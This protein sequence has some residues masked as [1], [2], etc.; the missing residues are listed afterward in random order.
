[1]CAVI[2]DIRIFS[3][4]KRPIEVRFKEHEFATK[5]DL[6]MSFGK[7]CFDETTELTAICGNRSLEDV[8]QMS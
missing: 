1:M 7:V 4:N 2:V 5:T 3:K 6:A 8:S